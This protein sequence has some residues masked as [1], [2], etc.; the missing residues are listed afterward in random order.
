MW[1]CYYLYVCVGW[2]VVVVVVVSAEPGFKIYWVCLWY[3]L[4]FIPI[5]HVL[6]LCLL[7]QENMSQWWIVW[8]NC[9]RETPT[10]EMT[11]TYCEKECVSGAI[12]EAGWS[13]IGEE[14]WEVGVRFDLVTVMATV[15]GDI[16]QRFFTFLVR[17]Y[18]VGFSM[19]FCVFCYV[20]KDI[21]ASGR[22]RLASVHPRI[23]AT[24]ETPSM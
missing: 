24:W 13:E 22:V 7:S 19:G 11:T 4:F 21:P 20:C 18:A 16:S 1:C 23:C 9:A 5:S 3:H 12:S 15:L 17:I 14:I 2:V 6:C 8:E 10:V